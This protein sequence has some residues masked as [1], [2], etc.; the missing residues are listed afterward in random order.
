MSVQFV[1]GDK[2][3]VEYSYREF[4]EGVVL[5]TERY[6]GLDW[7]TVRPDEQEMIFTFGSSQD[8][9]RGYKS[10]IVNDPILGKVTKI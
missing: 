1:S 9:E 4:F 7:V 10:Y 6:S 8:M 3:K 5:W 2:V